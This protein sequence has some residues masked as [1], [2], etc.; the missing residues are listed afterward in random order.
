[1]PVSVG[2]ARD[3]HFTVGLNALHH[4]LSLCVV[5]PVTAVM[6]VYTLVFARR[7]VA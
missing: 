1:M 6:A 4:V 5:C 3:I 7:I 2:A